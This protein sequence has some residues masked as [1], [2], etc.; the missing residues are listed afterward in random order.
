MLPLLRIVIAHLSPHIMQRD[1]LSENVLFSSF[2]QKGVEKGAGSL[3][4]ID[5][6][7]PSSDEQGVD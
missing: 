2:G 6:V 4:F 1:N 7:V 3:C 5:F